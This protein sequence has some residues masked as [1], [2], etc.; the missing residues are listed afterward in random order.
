MAVSAESI[1]DDTVD[2]GWQ[3]PLTQLSIITRFHPTRKRHAMPM[4]TGRLGSAVWSGCQRYRWPYQ[5]PRAG[6]DPSYCRYNLRVLSYCM[7]TPDAMKHPVRSDFHTVV[8]EAGV[9]VTFKPTNSVYSFCRLADANDVGC[10]GPISFAGVLH[11]EHNTTE[12]YSP[13]EVQDLAQRIASEFV[14]S[15]WFQQRSPFA[16]IRSAPT[17]A[18]TR[19]RPVSFAN[20]PRRIASEVAAT[21]RLIQNRDRAD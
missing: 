9:S 6:A 4:T 8:T 20:V 13:D 5:F 3:P 2:A 17:D 21:L 1:A 14:G 10:L 11:A 18:I 12:D 15:V 7:Q 16:G 19:L